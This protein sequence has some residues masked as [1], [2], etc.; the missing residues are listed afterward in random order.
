MLIKDEKC[1][2][3][4]VLVAFHLQ[5]MENLLLSAKVKTKVLT[6]Y[7]T[8]APRAMSAALVRDLWGSDRRL[9]CQKCHVLPMSSGLHLVL[10]F[11]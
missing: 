9:P 3:A 4:S 7:H 10:R 2:N 8:L 11:V 5:H 1:C 6:T